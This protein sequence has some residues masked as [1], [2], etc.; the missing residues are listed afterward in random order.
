[1]R[2]LT[3]LLMI[4]AALAVSA[5]AGCGE[6]ERPAAERL[7]RPAAIARIDALCRR[8]LEEVERAGHEPSV[9]SATM[10][11]LARYERWQERVLTLTE[12]GLRRI[13]RV[14]IPDDARAKEIQAYVF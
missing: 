12:A 6:Q 14:A 7:S 13:E 9:A 10:L 11:A 1:M 8:T 3:S 5:V 4:A 2:L